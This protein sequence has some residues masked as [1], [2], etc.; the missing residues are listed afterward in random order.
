M[1]GEDVGA[2]DGG[3]VDAVSVKVVLLVGK[4]VWERN[5]KVVSWK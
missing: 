4:D 5:G 2:V 1:K 3:C